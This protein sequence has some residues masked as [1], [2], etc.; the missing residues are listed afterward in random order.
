MWG[1]PPSHLFQGPAF[2]DTH[3]LLTR[4]VD[5]KR[6]WR[7][8][9]IQK[10]EGR[11]DSSGVHRYYA[12]FECPECDQ[13]VERR[14]DHGMEQS[15]CG[16]ARGPR[17]N[18]GA[19]KGKKRTP[20]YSIWHGMKQRCYCPTNLSYKRYGGRGIFVCKEWKH[21]YLAFKGWSEKNGYRKGLSLD[22]INNN[23]PYS[24]ENCRWV[25][26]SL[27]ITKR[28]RDARLGEHVG[29]L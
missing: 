1:R 24:P 29:A 4:N 17:Q 27:N 20:N 7:M 19:T 3:S 21:N 9:L 5:Q 16:C 12:L 15:T 28:F 2:H 11:K 22:R 14:I 13:L 25:P 10:T 18:H 23:G 6:E 8:K 26:L